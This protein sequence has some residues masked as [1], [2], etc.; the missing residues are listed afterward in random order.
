LIARELNFASFGNW[1]I[2]DEMGLEDGHGGGEAEGNFAE[3]DELSFEDGLFGGKWTTADI[4][5]GDAGG[6]EVCLIL[7]WLR[8]PD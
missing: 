2:G 1:H 6:M 7:L 3:L 4:E 8:T 5:D